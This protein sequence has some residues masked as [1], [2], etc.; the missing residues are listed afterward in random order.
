M[1]LLTSSGS[2]LTFGE[3]YTTT[4]SA[5]SL[6]RSQWGN[7]IQHC[8]DIHIFERLINVSEIDELVLG[9]DCIGKDPK[10]AKRKLSLNST[11]YLD[12]PS[13]EGSTL[14]AGLRAKVGQTENKDL[15]IVAV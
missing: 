15:A 5:S 8:P 4:S 9:G 10:A 12:C 7:S 1:T 6:V 2:I 11:E 13:R 3:D 14:T